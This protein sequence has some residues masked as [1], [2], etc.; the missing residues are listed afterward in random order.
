MSE[1]NFFSFDRM[2]RRRAYQERQRRREANHQAYLERQRRREANHQ[3]YLE[4]QARREANRVAY[5]ERLVSNVLRFRTQYENTLNDI[6]RQGL[7]V[8]IR[9]EF[10]EVSQR[11]QQIDILLAREDVEGARDL[12]L[13]IGQSIHGLIPRARQEKRRAERKQQRLM[14]E[15]QARL[16]AE[17]RKQARQDF[18]EQM[19]QNLEADKESN[20]DAVQEAVQK[21]DQLKDNVESMSDIDL[22]DQLVVDL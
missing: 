9:R 18:I 10:D 3:A 2:E 1:F 16:E 20:P 17:I 5:F 8:F 11:I 19:K 13:E 21:L 14:Q 6:K 7:D 15:E 12:S 22:Q 4:R